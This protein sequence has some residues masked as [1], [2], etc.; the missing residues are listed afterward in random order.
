MSDYVRQIIRDKRQW[1]HQV[2]P[3]EEALGFRG[4]HSRGYLPHFDA[5]GLQQFITYRLADS[6][7]AERRGEWEAF[8]HLEDEREKRKQIEAYLDLGHGECH[9]RDA[10]IAALVQENLLH[11]DGKDYRVLAWAIMPNHV[12]TL[13]EIWQK[14]LAEVVKSWK[15]YTAKQANKILGRTGMF[16]QG[17]YYDTYM[18]DEEHFRKTV[19][20]I[21][22]NP[23][24]ARLV[25]APEDWVWSSARYRGE[26]GA[27]V[28]VLH[29]Q[30]SGA[31]T[32]R[33][34]V[35]LFSIYRTVFRNCSSSRI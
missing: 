34:F 1:H 5:P 16:W 23:T 10:R 29:V 28:P 32:S 12:H 17:E 15:S 11:F 25:R 13:I 3:E 9:L 20:Y 35:G 2:T 14:P 18:R 8:L 6:L 31:R 30:S 22:N 4:W 27:V 26:P 33:A 21:E 7:P 24:K 19:R